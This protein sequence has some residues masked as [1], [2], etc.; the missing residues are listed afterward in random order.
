MDIYNYIS[1]QYLKYWF[2]TVAKPQISRPLMY[3]VKSST[4]PAI[5]CVWTCQ[6]SSLVSPL[7]YLPCND[8]NVTHPLA[9]CWPEPV[10]MPTNRCQTTFPVIPNKFCANVMLWD[11]TSALYLYLSHIPQS[12]VQPVV[13]VLK[14]LF[15]CKHSRTEQVHLIK[16]RVYET[17]QNSAEC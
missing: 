5:N 2:W 3:S 15:H 17:E 12:E 1:H 11:Y 7:L 10:K 6:R 14:Q 4:H 9:L 8:G 13:F 16:Q